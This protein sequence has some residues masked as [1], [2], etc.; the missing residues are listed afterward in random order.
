MHELKKNN[1]Y[2]LSGVTT[3]V[4]ATA[5]LWGPAGLGGLG[6]TKINYEHSHSA[7]MNW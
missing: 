4:A 1:N 6:P 5:L 3:V 7:S 2:W